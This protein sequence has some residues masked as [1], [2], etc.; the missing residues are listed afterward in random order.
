[1]TRILIATYGSEG[2][3]R[4]FTALAAGLIEHGFDV[5][6]CGEASGAEIARRHHVPF[7]ALDG[8]LQGIMATGEM[9]AQALRRSDGGI[10]GLTVFHRLARR[11]TESWM[12]VLVD[13]ASR[14]DV[15]IGSGLATYAA[16]SSAEATGRRFVGASPVPIT[17][18]R[19]FPSVFAIPGTVP[20]R[21]NRLS[22][23]IGARA[24]WTAFRRPTNHA[25]EKHGLEELRFEWAQT[26]VLYGFSPA[27]LPAPPDWPEGLVVCGDWS[28]PPSQVWDPP[29]ELVDFLAAGEPPVY[30]GFGSMAGFDAA[31]LVATVIAGLDGRRAIVAG[32]WAG[33]RALD[34]PE[35]VLTIERAPHSWLLPKCSL[36][37]HHCGAGTTHAVARAGIPS[38]PMPF[39]ADQPFWARLLR[40][41]GLA[42]RALHWKRLTEDAVRD[43]V[44]AATDAG[45][46]A[47]AESMSVE[48]ADEDGIGTAVAELGRVLHR[49]G[50]AG[51]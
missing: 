19:V 37:I 44:L 18:T 46:R 41:R 3:T 36:A 5:V 12:D 13:E 43:G 38:V 32:G 7:R 6:V 15:V 9:G 34:L 21:L 48:M 1:M 11:H 31:D 29:G 8:D 25:R 20:R 30:V 10:T 35:T 14:S 23:E 50:P 51:A 27:L 28:L 45:M 4:P 47:V 17:P 2:D 22:H 42:T 49:S 39:V 40:E 16:V 26:P 33:A 24:L